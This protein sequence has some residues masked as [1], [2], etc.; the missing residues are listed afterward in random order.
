MA[1]RG[2]LLAMIALNLCTIDS[3]TKRYLLKL[4]ESHVY[5]NKEPYLCTEYYTTSKEMLQEDCT[6]CHKGQR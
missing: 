5:A 1:T 3:D 6:T 2:I 4:P